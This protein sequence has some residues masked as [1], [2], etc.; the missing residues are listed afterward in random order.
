MI[1]VVAVTLLLIGA[2]ASGVGFAAVPA[3]P[4]ISQVEVMTAN[5]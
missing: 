1:R 2:L 4:S 5:R 3:S